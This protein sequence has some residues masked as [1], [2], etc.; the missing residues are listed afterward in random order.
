MYFSVFN[1]ESVFGEGAG[2]RVDYRAQEFGR[3]LE[4]QSHGRSLS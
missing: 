3:L 2:N 4:I 1:L